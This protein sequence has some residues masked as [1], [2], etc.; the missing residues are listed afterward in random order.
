MVP[1]ATDQNQL[2]IRYGKSIENGFDRALKT[3]IKLKEERR[4]Q[5]A[6]EA[7]EEALRNE[8]EEV[9]KTGTKEIVVGSCVKV[10]GVEFEVW[11]KSEAM[12]SLALS[13]YQPKNYEDVDV[14]VVPSVVS[15]P[16]AGV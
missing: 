12:L 10:Q 16:V 14:T 8:A 5:E 11:D 3:M 2:M 9:A 13:G 1:K 7:E 4:K 6:Q 15:E